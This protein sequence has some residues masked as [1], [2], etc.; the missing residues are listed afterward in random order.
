[1]SAGDYFCVENIIEKSYIYAGNTLINTKFSI[2]V[3]KVIF[4]RHQ[5]LTKRKQQMKKTNL[6]HQ[7]K[8]GLPMKK[9]KVLSQH[10]LISHSRY[11]YIFSCGICTVCIIYEYPFGD[12]LSTNLN[13]FPNATV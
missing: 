3:T 12:G 2:V 7:G 11:G 8:R 13:L 10:F 9:F 5:T 4:Q 6:Q 1:M